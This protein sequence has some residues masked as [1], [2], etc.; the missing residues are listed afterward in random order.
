MSL[1]HHWTIQ[2]EDPLTGD[3]GT[4]GPYT[5]SLNETDSSVYLALRNT[6][7]THVSYFYHGQH[8]GTFEFG[9]LHR[10]NIA[11]R[12]IKDI[13][14]RIV[15]EQKRKREEQRERWR[16][17]FQPVLQLFSRG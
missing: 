17:M 9:Y 8:V 11:P 4:L 10:P 13:R 12:K 5:T 15:E 3:I 1:P 2:Y 16:R 14:R 6:D 7:V